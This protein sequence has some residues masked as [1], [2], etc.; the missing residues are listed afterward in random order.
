MTALGYNPEYWGPTPEV[1]APKK[2][3]ARDPSS[4]WYDAAGRPIATGVKPGTYLRQPVKG[5]FVP[6]ADGLRSCLGK[7]F[8]L[9]QMVAFL[10]I[11]FAGKRVRI[12]RNEG[13]S[14][15]EADKRA[16]GVIQRSEHRLTLMVREE[17][18]ICVDDR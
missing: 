10:A 16:W 2:W 8:A 6:F 17:I 12:A 3:D 7:K 15:E 18:G 9:V 13:E 4:G 14:Q 5:A 1:F 11:M